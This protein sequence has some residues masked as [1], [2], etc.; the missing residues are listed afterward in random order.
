MREPIWKR[1]EPSRRNN[2]PRP[3]D[4][5]GKGQERWTTQNVAL[6]VRVSTVTIRNSGA[7]AFWTVTLEQPVTS[8]VTLGPAAAEV[9]S[10]AWARTT[11]A[12][13]AARGFQAR[14]EAVLW[15]DYADTPHGLMGYRVRVG[16]FPT[17]AAATAQQTAITAAGFTAI[18]EWT[19]YDAQTVGEVSPDRSEA[20]PFATGTVLRATSATTLFRQLRR[21]CIV[22]HSCSL[23]YSKTYGRSG[24]Y[25][26]VAAVFLKALC[27]FG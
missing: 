4:V 8:K 20:R 13:L 6:G 5:P 2:R 21:H 9:E 1:S 16:E 15:P 14:V 25:R 10:A 27:R 7:A 18:T 22:V 17:Q 11:A 23:Q 26:R 3:H 19:G 12:Q 24:S